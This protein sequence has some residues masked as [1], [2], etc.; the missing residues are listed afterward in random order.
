MCVSVCVSLLTLA[1]LVQHETEDDG[2]EEQHAEDHV[3]VV[4]VC[5]ERRA[6]LH[7]R[8]GPFR[9]TLPHPAPPCPTLRHTAPP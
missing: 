3:D 7:S 2:A 9:F 6:S 4:Q 5:R 8:H 1:S